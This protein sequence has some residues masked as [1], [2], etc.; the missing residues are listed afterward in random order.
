MT[1]NSKCR[2]CGYIG[3]PQ[4]RSTYKKRYIPTATFIC[5]KCKSKNVSPT[6]NEVLK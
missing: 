4:I 2:N 6:N 1:E 3:P 5:T